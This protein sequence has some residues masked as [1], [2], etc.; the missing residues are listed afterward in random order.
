MLQCLLDGVDEAPSPD[1]TGSTINAYLEFAF[2]V[3]QNYFKPAGWR[4]PESESHP[5]LGRGG[6]V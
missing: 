1:V 3:N 2:I 5:G 6:S 4:R